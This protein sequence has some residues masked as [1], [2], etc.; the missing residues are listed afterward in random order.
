MPLA[1]RKAPL[2]VKL[3]AAAISILA[4][5]TTTELIL[6][7]F[8]PELSYKN[9][10]FPFNRDI[11]FVEFYEKDSEIFWKLRENQ[12]VESRWFSSLSYQINSLGLRGPEVRKEKHGYRI[13]ALGNSC[14]F[15][16]GVPFEK[17]WTELLE[18]QLNEVI[19]G[20]SIEVVNAGVPGYSSYQGKIHLQRLLHLKPDI[21]LIMFGWNDHW[22]AGNDISDAEQ[23]SPPQV[24]IDLQNELS[25]LMLY[26]LM[27]KATL[28]LTED[29][30]FVRLDDITGKRRVSQDEFAENLRAIIR[31]AKVNAV[32]PVLVVPPV[33][34]LNLYFKGIQSNFHMLH[35]RY[36]DIIVKVG[37]YQGIPVVNLQI[38][39]DNHNDLYDDAQG[40]PIHFNARGQRLAAENIAE[41]IMTLRR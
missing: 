27:R 39:F 18:S 19:V 13:L 5:V 37:K 31:I 30:T 17:C 12:T 29:T 11:N 8:D 10:F 40:D 26:K 9:Q 15:G 22:R 36:R 14:T 28:T 1:H 4:F 25:Q 24:V 38:P 33:A 23:N 35:A 32:A 34:S 6:R 21:V 41:T 2:Y 20:D 16:W 7:L 3:M